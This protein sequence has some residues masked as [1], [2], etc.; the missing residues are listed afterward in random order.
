MSRSLHL[1]GYDIACA[2]SRKQVA[3]LLKP[4]RIGG[5]RSLAECW[6]SDDEFQAIWPQLQA[7]INPQTDSLLA[8][9]HDA[10]GHDRHFGQGQIA[11]GPTLI[12]G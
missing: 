2:H 4:W 11:T 10:R 8:L 9:R 12:V 3:A 6:L 5:Q 1:I 7:R